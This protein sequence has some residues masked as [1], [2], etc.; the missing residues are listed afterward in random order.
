MVVLRRCVSGMKARS[1]MQEISVASFSHRGRKL[2]N[3]DYSGVYEFSENRVGAR[4]LAI[5]ADGMGGHNAGEVASRAAVETIAGKLSDSVFSL[6]SPDDL[7][8]AVTGA[9][10]TASETIFAKASSEPS[11]RGMGTTASVVLILADRAIVANVGD[12]RIYHVKGEG[13]EQLSEDHTAL[14]IAMKAGHMTD[15]EIETFPYKHAIT[16]SLGEE[17]APEIFIRT[18]GRF[19]DSS[20]IICSDGLTDVISEGEIYEQ[21]TG[22]PDLQIAVD[23]LGRLAYQSGSEDNITVVGLEIGV[24]RRNETPIGGVE[25]VYPLKTGDKE[26]GR[27]RKCACALAL[28]LVLLLLA[29]IS[30]GL[31]YYFNFSEQG[32]FDHI[33][34]RAVIFK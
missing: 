3:E 32:Y 14:S 28:I 11:C 19:F 12:S 25:K 8:S 29:V 10:R 26:Q 5:I 15:E 33:A 31:I 9:F 22:N 23:T 13:I 24:L 17:S 6:Q 16:R 2:T 4:R 1:Y 20:F 7:T 18:V 34:E 27:G 21:V 30:A